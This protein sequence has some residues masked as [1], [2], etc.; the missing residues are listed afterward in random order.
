MSNEQTPPAASNNWG[1]V[2]LLL[3]AIGFVHIMALGSL[4]FDAI[5]FMTLF[6]LLGLAI[7]TVGLFKKPRKAAVCGVVLGL[8]GLMFLPT[9]FLPLLHRS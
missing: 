8:S 4:R 9:V 5:R 2:G 6:S 7:S 3:S 1:M